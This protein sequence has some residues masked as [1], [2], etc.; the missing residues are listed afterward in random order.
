MSKRGGNLP[1]EEQTH[2]LRQILAA[3]VGNGGAL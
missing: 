1:Y 3:I 2:L